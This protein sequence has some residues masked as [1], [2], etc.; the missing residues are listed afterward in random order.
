MT[1]ALPIV[2]KNS[3]NLSEIQK[4]HAFGKPRQLRFSFEIYCIYLCS[5]SNIPIAVPVDAQK[6]NYCKCQERIPAQLA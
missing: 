5:T 3:L 6:L 4:I 1:L 2:R